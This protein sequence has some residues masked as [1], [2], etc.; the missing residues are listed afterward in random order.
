MNKKLE[1]LCEDELVVALSE[2]EADLKAG[3][4]YLESVEEHLKRICV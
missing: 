4:Y 1:P 3:K 2:T